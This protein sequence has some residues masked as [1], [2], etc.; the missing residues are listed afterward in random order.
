MTNIRRTICIFLALILCLALALP[1][2]ASD[3]PESTEA[4][5]ETAAA[6]EAPA[7]PDDEPIDT[8]ELAEPEDDLTAEEETSVPEESA[9]SDEE[10]APEEDESGM[11]TEEVTVPADETPSE[12]PEMPEDEASSEELPDAEAALPSDGSSS[13]P[14][15]LYLH[16]EQRGWCTLASCTMMLRARMFLSGNASWSSITQTGVY[17]SAWLPGAGLYFNFTY[18][19]N[20]S[21]MTVSHATVSGMSVGTLK[22][23]LDAHPEGIVL[24]VYDVPHAIFV[25][26]YEGDTFYGSDPANKAGVGRKPISQTW[27]ASQCGGTQAGILS[28]ADAYWYI[29]S[30][31]IKS[32]TYYTLKF[33]ANGGTI[34]GDSSK[35]VAGG[36]AVGTLPTA[37]RSGYVFD[38][39]YTEKNG[40][41]KITSS[42]SVLKSQTLYAHWY[43]VSG[44]ISF[45]SSPVSIHLEKGIN[46][47]TVTVS[48]SGTLNKVRLEYA[49]EDRAKND[50]TAKW[51]GET[52]NNKRTIKF[53]ASSTASGAYHAT[54]YMYDTDTN[55]LINSQQLTINVINED[56]YLEVSANALRLAAD[57]LSKE[58]VDVFYG[59]TAGD[60]PAG[61]TLTCSV[62]KTYAV[63]AYLNAWKDGKRTLNI[64]PVEG[65]QGDSCVATVTLLLKDPSG[66]VCSEQ[67]IS[68]TVVQTSGVCGGYYEGNVRW[69]LD[70]Q[71]LYISI[72][73]PNNV[74]EGGDMW[75]YETVYGRAPW[76][77]WA[78]VIESVVIDS[79]VT[80]IGSCAFYGCSELR[81]I[82]IAETV[83]GIG[84][85]AF[86]GCSALTYIDVPGSV[87]FVAA[88]A[89]KNCSS[90]AEIDFHEGTTLLSEGALT[91]CSALTTLYIPLSMTDLQ[92]STDTNIADIWYNGS[93]AEWDS[94]DTA[95]SIT[96]RIPAGAV[97]HCANEDTGTHDLASA[98]RILAF[99]SNAD[100]SEDASSTDTGL[101]EADDVNS[102]GSITEYDA[103]LIL[104]EIVGF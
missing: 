16:Q 101:S 82:S 43:A 5:P 47:A 9:V 38:G 20:G 24:Y 59:G 85:R 29:S 54:F 78:D 95:C 73:D 26:D 49:L 27:L 34:S 3:E 83:S 17:P 88:D 53:T 30:Y 28:R 37:T 19:I 81:M 58:T 23:L 104:R 8:E 25:S 75:N 69:E 41:T 98:A 65:W 71:T 14:S 80:R 46:T 18:S 89:F 100:I 56:I 1:A 40:G 60:L 63:T 76:Y 33:D 22:A 99:T 45:S 74:N 90:L 77:L 96:D 48:G 36:S 91:G 15:D 64:L 62:D 4:E 52:S 68:V 86:S 84:D 44:T 50:I 2:A 21:R 102:D 10:P 66:D 12:E 35:T 31:S 13:L 32:T 55:N 51:T 42:S 72:I 87:R 94:L 39:W 11:P 61:Y 70:G 103:A 92:V 79:G 57:T 93:R 97:I 7:E 67:N 6:D